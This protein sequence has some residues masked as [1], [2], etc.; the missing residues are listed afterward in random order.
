MHVIVPLKTVLAYF[1]CTIGR[2]GGHDNVGLL[3]NDIEAAYSAFVEEL[4][5]VLMSLLLLQWLIV[6]RLWMVA[7]SNHP[8]WVFGC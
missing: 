1:I 6:M 3:A 8:S 5:E 2:V 4:G 7:P